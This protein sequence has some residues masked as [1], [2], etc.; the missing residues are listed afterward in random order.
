M[1]RAEKVSK[2]YG[3]KAA[4]ADL[5]LSVEA[6]TVLGFIG[7]NGAGKTTTMRILA[8]TMPPSSGR[9]SI[10]G[11]DMDGDPLA[12]K[13]VIGYLPENAPLYSHMRVRPFLEF[14]AR[15]RGVSEASLDQ[16]VAV[17]SGR[18]ALDA[19]LD[20]ELESLSKGFRRRVCLAQAIIH[21]PKVLLLD[22]P[23]DGLDPVQKL[24][25]RSLIREMRDGRAIIVS[26]HILEELDAVCDR[27]LA[28]SEGRKIFDGSKDEFK[29][30]GRGSALELELS[31][32]MPA[33]I[34]AESFRSLASVK[35]VEIA[36]ESGSSLKLRLFPKDGLDG[37]AV[38][39]ALE[40]A[41]LSGWAAESCAPVKPSRLDDVFTSLIEASKRASGESKP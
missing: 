19:V 9:V 31:C 23:T 17:A 11:F 40:L 26:T 37:K 10:C 3:A 38:V 33:S 24:Q 15:M 6:G 2:L 34:A 36:C 5:D 14:C 35:A 18:C 39:E 25:I 8:G 29:S 21:D 12:A 30:S 20:D 22:E 16:A 41:R 1:V 27:V 28:I 4:L 32:T 13:S 7:P